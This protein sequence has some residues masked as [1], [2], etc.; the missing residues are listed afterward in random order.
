M[1]NESGWRG[2]WDIRQRA[3]LCWSPRISGNCLM[4]RSGTHILVVAVLV[5]Q[6]VSGTE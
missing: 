1:N 2:A 4:S 5:R 3:D 6:G